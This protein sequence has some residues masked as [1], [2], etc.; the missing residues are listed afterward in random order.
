MRCAAGAKR[1]STLSRRK[2]NSD[3]KRGAFMAGGLLAL[4]CII[5]DMHVF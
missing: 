5:R 2:N 1:R 4:N 3:E